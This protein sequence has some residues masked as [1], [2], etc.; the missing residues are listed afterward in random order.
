MDKNEILAYYRSLSIGE[1]LEL[2]DSICRLE[3]DCEGQYIAATGIYDFEE[4]PTEVRAESVVVIV[5][6]E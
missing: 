3:I 4:I 2:M 1:Q 6:E 5:M